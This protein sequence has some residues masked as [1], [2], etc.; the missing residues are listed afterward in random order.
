MNLCNMTGLKHV[1]ST[2]LTFR[3]KASAEMLSLE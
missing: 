1:I 3:F 2:A